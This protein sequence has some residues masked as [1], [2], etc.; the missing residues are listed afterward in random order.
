MV[1]RFSLSVLGEILK[2]HVHRIE[3]LVLP[4]ELDVDVDIEAEDGWDEL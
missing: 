4:V 2:K 3:M 1:R